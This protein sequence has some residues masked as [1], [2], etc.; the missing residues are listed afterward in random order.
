MP[1]LIASHADTDNS[2][3]ISLGV[4]GTQRE[5][6]LRRTFGYRATDAVAQLY[7]RGML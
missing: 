2:C 7:I 4:T 1:L 6:K 3:R 5:V